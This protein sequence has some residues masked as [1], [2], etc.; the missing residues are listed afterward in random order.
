VTVP[1]KRPSDWPRLFR[2]ACSLIDQVNKGS[3]IIKEWTFGGG[4][5]M[6]LQIGHRESHDVDIFLSDAQQLPFLN[7]EVNDLKFEVMP[8]AYKG[9]GTR[10]LKFIFEEGEID[11]IAVPTLTENPTVKRHVEGVVTLLET[12]PEIITKKVFFRGE[13]I[14]PRDIF[15]IA[16]AGT[17]CADEIVAALKPHREK[18]EATLTAMGKLNPEFVAKVIA[19]LMI[20]EKYE[21]LSQSSLESAKALLETARR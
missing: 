2:I 7:P 20:R 13:H 5:A 8:A 12:V 11:F 19:A 1:A 18:I 16:A 15:D 21:E 14:Q 17:V 10:S 3:P 4:T 6:M 9:D